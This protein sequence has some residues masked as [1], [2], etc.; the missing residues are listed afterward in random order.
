MVLHYLFVTGGR[1]EREKRQQRLPCG[2]ES[3]SLQEALN[4]VVHGHI[5]VLP[6]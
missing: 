2:A 5:D 3:E 6:V 4:L 1:G